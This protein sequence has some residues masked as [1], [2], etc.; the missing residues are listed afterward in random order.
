MRVIYVCFF[1]M[2]LKQ[3]IPN[4]PQPDKDWADFPGF[5]AGWGIREQREEVLQG[6]VRIL[7]T[8]DCSDLHQE[9]RDGSE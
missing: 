1:D 9:S 2:V 7:E 6:G 4:K 3:H 5:S 8:M